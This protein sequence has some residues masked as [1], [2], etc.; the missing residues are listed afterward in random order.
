MHLV[1]DQGFG[2]YDIRTLSIMSVK[3]ILS[4]RLENCSIRCFSIQ[5][6]IRV[7]IYF[8]DI[9]RFPRGGKGLCVI[10]YFIALGKLGYHEL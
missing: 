8:H 7:P 3:V 6:V 9:G 1:S 5:T 10:K 2:M 4:F